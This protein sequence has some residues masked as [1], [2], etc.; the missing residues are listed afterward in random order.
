[1]ITVVVGMIITT[2]TS[3]ASATKPDHRRRGSVS[4]L[5]GV[6]DEVALVLERRAIRREARDGRARRRLHRDPVGRERD[7]L[8]AREAEETRGAARPSR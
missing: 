4:R 5:V 3:L 8:R 7:A 6:L 1:M 2:A